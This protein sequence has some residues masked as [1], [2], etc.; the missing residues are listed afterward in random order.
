MNFEF[1]INTLNLYNLTKSNQSIDLN[2]IVASNKCVYFGITT[3]GIILN[4]LNITVLR[5]GKLKDKTFKYFMIISVADLVYMCIFNLDS[6]MKIFQLQFTYIEQLFQLCFINYFTSCLAIFV[7]LVDLI[8]A[9]NRCF[10][11]RNKYYFQNLN[12]QKV[13]TVFIVFS[14]VAY[15]PE[16]LSK[17]I[18]FNQNKLIYDLAT[19]S[20]GNSNLY[21]LLIFLT[22]TSR[23]FICSFMLTVINLYTMVLLIKRKSLKLKQNYKMASKYKN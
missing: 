18:V 8:N 12:I 13:I 16:I 4:S 9:L 19:S 17:E 10:I 23:M 1:R 15:L 11:C 7:I 22:W 2:S 5:S 14:T 3:L 21:R 6:L 20:W